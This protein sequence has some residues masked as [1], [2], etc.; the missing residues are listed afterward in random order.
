MRKYA[1][2]T[3]DLQTWWFKLE[4]QNFIHLNNQVRKVAH[5]LS[6]FRL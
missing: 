3:R 6:Y 1:D 5:N 4:R 2:I